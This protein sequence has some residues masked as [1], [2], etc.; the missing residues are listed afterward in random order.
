LAAFIAPNRYSFSCPAAQADS[1]SANH[2]STVSQ[3]MPEAILPPRAPPMPSQT[4]A[5]AVP[6]GSSAAR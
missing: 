4:R 2:C 5:H 6:S 3:A 1:V